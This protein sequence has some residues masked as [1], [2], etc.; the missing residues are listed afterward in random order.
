MLG[1]RDARR[2]QPSQPIKVRNYSVET[3]LV[4]TVAPAR[5]PL[6]IVHLGFRPF[7]GAWLI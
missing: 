2:S 5:W 3:H 1:D 4:G 7:L 6:A